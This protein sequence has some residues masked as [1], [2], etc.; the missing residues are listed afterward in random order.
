[1]DDSFASPTKRLA[2]AIDAI[3]GNPP[4]L[5]RADKKGKFPMAA[6][7]L[8]AEGFYDML[9]LTVAM[10]EESF[11]RIRDLIGALIEYRPLLGDGDA[12]QSSTL[13]TDE[14]RKMN[15]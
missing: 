4:K 7:K 9:P 15:T 5:A 12:K 2:A 10:T 3:V 13:A 6:M 14:N 1:V 11:D 8:N